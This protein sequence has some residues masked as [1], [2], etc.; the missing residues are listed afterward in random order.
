MKTIVSSLLLLLVTFSYG[1]LFANGLENKDS[2]V[3]VTTNP[4]YT[5][6]IPLWFNVDVEFKLSEKNTIS[7]ILGGGKLISYETMTDSFL[8]LSDGEES[9][10]DFYTVGIGTQFRRYLFSKT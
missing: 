4:L 8:A 10:P 2:S 6:F 1:N 5:I 3:S 9:D 7:V